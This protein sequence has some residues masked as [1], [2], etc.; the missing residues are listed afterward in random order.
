MGVWSAGGKLY[1]DAICRVLFPADS[2]FPPAVP[3]LLGRR[4][5][6]DERPVLLHQAAH[7]THLPL[8]PIVSTHTLFLVDN[9]KENGLH[10]PSQLVIAPDY[11]PRP[12]EWNGD[13]DR[14]EYLHLDCMASIADCVECMRERETGRLDV[15]VDVEDMEEEDEEESEMGLEGEEGE[16]H[17]EEE[18]EHE[19]EEETESGVDEHEHFTSD[20]EAE[21]RATQ[22]DSSM[23]DADG[24]DE[25]MD[26]EAIAN[27]SIN[28]RQ[29]QKTAA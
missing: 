27:A 21:H 29:T 23:Y 22:L 17:G 13:R 4:A 5:G 6:G 20:D 26:D 11:L 25:L 14:D 9:R 24:A 16:E 12:W 10:F 15:G 3:T 18:H 8:L 1:V 2:T 7:Y 28:R 19:E